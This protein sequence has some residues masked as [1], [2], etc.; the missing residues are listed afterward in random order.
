VRFA[1]ENTV[2]TEALRA[3][4]V[5]PMARTPTPLR[6]CGAYCGHDLGADLFWMAAAHA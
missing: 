1:R 5:T 3:A 6:P 2:D 4:A